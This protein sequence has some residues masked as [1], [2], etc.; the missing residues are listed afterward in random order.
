[1]DKF[2]NALNQFLQFYDYDDKEGTQK[3][4]AFELCLCLGRGYTRFIDQWI[5]FATKMGVE[6]LTI[7]FNCGCSCLPPN[8]EM[9]VLRREFLSQGKEF[10][11]K[12]LELN[13]CD[14][15]PNLFTKFCNLTTLNLVNVRLGLSDVQ[16]ICA[17]CLSLITLLM[18]GCYLPLN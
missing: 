7:S 11:L 5:T 16:T 13:T 17:C 4:V 14:L 2:I 8:E 1:M 15:G 3:T 9:Y 12:Y 6:N 18:D 10:N